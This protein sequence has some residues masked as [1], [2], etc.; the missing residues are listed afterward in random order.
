MCLA[1]H[2]CEE[3]NQKYNEFHFGAKGYNDSKFSMVVDRS[4]F[5]IHPDW[6]DKTDGSD[7][8]SDYCLVELPESVNDKRQENCGDNMCA[9]RVCLPKQAPTP[10]AACWVGG[11][12]VEDYAEDEV[13]AALK[14]IGVNIFS[15]EYT[16]AKAK[17]ILWN[18]IIFFDEFCAGLPDANNDG[19]TDAGGDSCSG[20][21][22]GGLVCR[23]DDKLIVYGLSSWG[24]NCG[25]KGK[26][27]VYANVFAAMS[28]IENTIGA[29]V[30]TTKQ[31]TTTTKTVPTTPTTPS[32]GDCPDMELRL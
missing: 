22:G 27:S 3:T 28:W 9:T 17:S 1:A 29:Q 6:T 8:N 30:T 18:D 24:D 20:D 4:A 15:E 14:S 2:C 21:S 10:G 19:F 26:P 23:E 32:A 7:M 31:T 13:P 11:F 5:T 12:G 25:K 16:K